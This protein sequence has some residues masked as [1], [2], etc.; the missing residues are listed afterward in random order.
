MV[1]SSVS[2]SLHQR[3]STFM[4]RGIFRTHAYV[5]G[6]LSFK[7]RSSADRVSSNHGNRR[8]DFLHVLRLGLRWLKL[9]GGI[10]F[11]FVFF[12]PANVRRPSFPQDMNAALD[13]MVCRAPSDE[14]LRRRDAAPPATGANPPS[15][16][17]FF[18]SAAARHAALRTNGSQSGRGPAWPPPPPAR[19]TA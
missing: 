16:L 7:Q 15:K 18:S 6:T 13:T 10:F 17:S 2:K 14:R 12:P 5:E 9:I 4:S 11:V 3:K 1:P 19:F 8:D